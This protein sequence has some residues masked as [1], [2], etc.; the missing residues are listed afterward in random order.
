MAR[1]PTLLTAHLYH[2]HQPAQKTHVTYYINV[3]VGMSVAVRV[4]VHPE[5]Q[6]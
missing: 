1:Q 5:A 4:A 2:M 6:V 3:W